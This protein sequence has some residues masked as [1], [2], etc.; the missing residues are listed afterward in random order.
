M[1]GA[2]ACGWIRTSVVATTV[3]PVPRA[4]SPAAA[5][6]FRIVGREP[7]S[8]DV[9]RRLGLRHGDAL[10]QTGFHEQGRDD[11]RGRRASPGMAFSAGSAVIGSQKSVTRPTSSVPR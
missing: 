4:N 9:H 8:E 5:K 3:M 1:N 10:A 11:R 6:L 7:A 2:S